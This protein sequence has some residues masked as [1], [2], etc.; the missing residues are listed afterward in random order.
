[1]IWKIYPCRYATYTNKERTPPL[2]SKGT[3]TYKAVR[4]A[5]HRNTRIAAT[6]AEPNEDIGVRSKTSGS[7]LNF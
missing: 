4:T 6:I 1:M 7:D 2:T 5:Q 3:I